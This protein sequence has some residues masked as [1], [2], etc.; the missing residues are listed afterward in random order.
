MSMMKSMI[1]ALLSLSLGTGLTMIPQARAADASPGTDQSVPATLSGELYLASGDAV[2]ELASTL[3][4]AR[5]NN[6]LALII[7][8]GNWCHD[9]RA[10]ASRLFKEPLRTMIDEHYQILFVDVG[11]L[12]K[13]KDVITRLG[14]PVYYATPTVLIVDPVSGQVINARNRHQWA[15]A[16]S[17]GMEESFNYFEEFANTDLTALPDMANADAHLRELLLEIDAFETVQADRIYR[18]YAVLGPMLRAYKEGDKKAFSDK[19]WNEVREY[20]YRVPA[21]IAVLRAEARRRTA[22]GETDIPLDFPAY[23]VFSWERN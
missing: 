11:Y 7:L 8:G 2:A 22:A 4:T 13:G 19:L 5:S 15:N 14:I 21:D 18:A 16:E 3:D 9:S 20:R 12:D 1:F 6:K 23:P 10:L 17:I